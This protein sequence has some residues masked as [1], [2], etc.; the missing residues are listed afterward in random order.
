MCL[1]LAYKSFL[2]IAPNMNCA[3]HLTRVV[4]FVDYEALREQIPELQFKMVD[5]QQ[6]EPYYY[7]QK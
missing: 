4:I 3:R 2:V 7:R 5:A 1:Y 6:D